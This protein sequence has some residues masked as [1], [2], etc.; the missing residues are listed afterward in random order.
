MKK[1]TVKFAF[2]FALFATVE[3]F[4]QA[5]PAGGRGGGGGGKHFFGTGIM[6][7]N[8]ETKQGGTG[9]TG[10]TLLSQ[11]DFVRMWKKLGYGVTFNYDKHGKNQTDSSY[12]LKLEYHIDKFYLEFG[13][14]LNATRAYTDRSIAEETGS[15]MMYG[16]GARFPVGKGAFFHAS[17]KIKSQTLKKQDGVEISEP[18][19]QTDG[20]PLFGFGFN[21]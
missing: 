16:F 11:T 20:Y 12:G 17:Y 21:F 14:L 9:P 7:L 4:S 8:S 5:K 1:I 10:S 15:G 2:L 19:T 18:I 3:S 6:F 13:Y